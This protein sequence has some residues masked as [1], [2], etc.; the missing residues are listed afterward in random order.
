MGLICDEIK[1]VRVFA[2]VS[3]TEQLEDVLLLLQQSFDSDVSDRH[4]RSRHFD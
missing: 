4:P 3:L 2:T 1:D